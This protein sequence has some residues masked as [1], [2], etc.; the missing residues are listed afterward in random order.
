MKAHSQ[1]QQTRSFP[2]GH[3]VNKNIRFVKAQIPR[4]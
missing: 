2:P 3:F 4:L 1:G